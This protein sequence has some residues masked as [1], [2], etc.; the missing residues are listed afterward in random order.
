MTC[1]F[2]IYPV[3]V[4]RFGKEQF[5]VVRLRYESSMFEMKTSSK[6]ADGLRGF[7][8]YMGG[9][10]GRTGCVLLSTPVEY[11]SK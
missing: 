7:I 4:V 6:V 1:A 3:L 2:Y 5:F 11:E 9:R 8:V 10:T